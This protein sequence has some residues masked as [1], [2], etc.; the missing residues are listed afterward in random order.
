MIH[1]KGQ[2]DYAM[3]VEIMTGWLTWWGWYTTKVK[4]G[5]VLV[6]GGGGGV[7]VSWW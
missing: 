2:D 4:I 7:V 3:V 5:M 6:S 1:Y